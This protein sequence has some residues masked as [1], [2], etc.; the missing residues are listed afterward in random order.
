MT[1]YV[2]L[3]QGA[4]RLKKKKRKEIYHFKLKRKQT[5]KDRTVKSEYYSFVFSQ[6]FILIN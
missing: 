6:Q 3:F 1:E 2:I 5:L 4:R